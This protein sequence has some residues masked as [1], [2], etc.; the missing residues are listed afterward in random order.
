MPPAIECCSAVFFRREKE[1]LEAQ[2]QQQRSELESEKDK[3][4]E[5]KMMLMEKIE[6]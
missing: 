1:Q 3:V 4:E 2:N 6:R 5:S